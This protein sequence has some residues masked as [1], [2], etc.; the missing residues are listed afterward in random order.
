MSAEVNYTCNTCGLNFGAG[1]YQRE[2]MKT[3]WHRYNLKRRVAELPPIPAEVFSQKMQQ[4]QQQQAAPAPSRKQVTKKDLKRQ[5]KEAKRN[6]QMQNGVAKLNLGRSESRSSLSSVGFSAGEPAR[7]FA[8]SSEVSTD[9]SDSEVDTR[10][11]TE[12]EASRH[13]STSKADDV[14]RLL[15][16]KLKSYVQMPPN[17]CFMDGHESATA[18][19]NFKYM[20]SKYGLVVPEEEH[21]ADW[22]G[23]MG[24]YNE[25]VGLGNC[26]LTCPYMGRSLAAARAHMLDKQHVKIPWDTDEERE[27][28][29]DFYDYS[30]SEDEGWEDVDGD[31]ADVEDVEDDSTDTGSM[32]ASRAHVNTAFVDG[33]ELILGDSG[34]SAG[35]RSL[36]RYF[37]QRAMQPLEKPG[38]KAVKM[39]DYRS[40]GVTERSAD[41]MVKAAWKEQKKAREQFSRGRRHQNFQQHFRDPLLQ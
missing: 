8:T 41:K 10:S 33:Y 5:E 2:H 1:D 16:E 3:D 29:I 15:K 34:R 25:K 11:E 14:D 19:D 17:I 13:G 21:V 9:I 28:I 7:D 36:N 26:C 40:P 38:R 37:K 31:D 18:L 22:E 32:A 39:I 35:H 20:Y 30:D 27:E 6:E 24:Y 23:L 12:S 4:I